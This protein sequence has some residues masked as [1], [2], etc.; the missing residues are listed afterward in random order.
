MNYC[1]KKTG[2]NHRIPT[3]LKEKDVQHSSRCDV[4][5]PPPNW[6]IFTGLFVGGGGDSHYFKFH[7]KCKPSVI[8][9]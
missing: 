7:A 1:G 2:A 4:L 3:T 9:I 5:V 6:R 8:F